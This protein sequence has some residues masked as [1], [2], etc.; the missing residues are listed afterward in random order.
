MKLTI[1]KIMSIVAL[2]SL[3]LFSFSVIIYA[4]TCAPG[5]TDC[6]D[7][8]TE[9][10]SGSHAGGPGGAAGQIDNPLGIND[11][12][13]IIGNVIKAA[14]GIVGSVALAV[15]ILG[16]LTWVVSAGNEEKIT[17]GK[18]MIMWAA[19]GLAVIF[20]SYAL[21]TFVITAIAGS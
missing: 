16:G 8:I 18:N 13:I 2:S 1:I 11:P 5:D 14:L 7:T 10:D 12:R 3:F 19:F 21:V 9:G 6:W 15:F 4:Q 20:M 17:K